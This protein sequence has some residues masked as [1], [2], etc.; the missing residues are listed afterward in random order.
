MAAKSTWKTWDLKSDGRLS[1]W[2]NTPG[3]CSS[4]SGFTNDRGC[5]MATHRPPS[6]Q[7]HSELIIF[8]ISGLCYDTNC[9]FS[10]A[11]ACWSIHYAKRLLETIFVH[12]F[13]HATMPLRN[14][15]KNCIYYWG[16]TAYVAYHVNH[17][18]FTSPCMMQVYAGLAGFLVSFYYRRL[19]ICKSIKQFWYFR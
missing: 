13:S 16:F 17:P 14:L 2:R 12:R 1:S 5:S 8:L 7:Q 11:A 18:L 15:F 4:I 9:L 19:C 10:M 6:A 3:H